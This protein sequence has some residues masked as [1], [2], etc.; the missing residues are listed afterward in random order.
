MLQTAQYPI[1]LVSFHHTHSPI[2][3]LVRCLRIPFIWMLPIFGF[4][5]PRGIIKTYIFNVFRCF[6]VAFPFYFSPLLLTVDDHFILCSRMLLLLL[7]SVFFF[8]HSTHF[9]S[10]IHKWQACIIFGEHSMCVFF[11]FSHYSSQMKLTLLLCVYTLLVS[12]D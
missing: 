6:N 7:L 5:G 3:L 8:I 12:Q 10:S 1:F 2:R 4:F 9:H 11:L